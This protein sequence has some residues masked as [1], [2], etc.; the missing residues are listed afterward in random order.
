MNIYS[1]LLGESLKERIGMKKAIGFGLAC[2]F[3]AAFAVNATVIVSDSFDVGEAVDAVNGIYRYGANAVDGTD[4][5]KNA[6]NQSVVT[7]GFSG[8][9]SGAGFVVPLLRSGT[10]SNGYANLRMQ[11]SANAYRSLETYTTAATYYFSMTVSVDALLSANQN[12]YFG[13]AGSLSGTL[14]GEGITKYGFLLGIES[15]GSSMDLIARTRQSDGSPANSLK[16]TTVLSGITAGEEYNIL[17]R[18][19]VNISGGVD[20]FSVWVNPTDATEANNTA[21][22][23]FDAAS[24][25]LFYGMPDGG[26]INSFAIY[27]AGG[28]TVA[29][30]AVDNVMM[31]T[32][33]DEV[34][35]NVNIEL[36]AELPVGVIAYDSFYATQPGDA[37]NGYYYAGEHRADAYAVLSGVSN[38]SVTAGGFSGDWS[39][40]G[41]ATVLPRFGNDGRV[42]L[43]MLGNTLAYRSLTPYSGSLANTYYFSM[44]V[45][46]HHD[47]VP[48]QKAYFGFANDL[49][50]TL[51]AEGSTKYGFLLGVEKTNGVINLIAR[52]RQSDGPAGISLKDTVVANLNAYQEYKLIVRM[53]RNISDG[54]DGL[55]VW[56]DPADPVESN[57]VPT[58]VFDETTVDSLFYGALNQDDINSFAF[59]GEGETNNIADVRV[60]NVM[61]ATAFDV[62]ID[63]FDS[64]FNGA[65]LSWSGDGSNSIISSSTLFSQTNTPF[66]GVANYL[67]YTHDLVTTAWTNIASSAGT[68][69]VSWSFPQDGDQGF[70]QVITQ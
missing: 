13:F 20:G 37:E 64:V 43:R 50:G 29:N 22:L 4:A 48:A 66:E 16:D 34:Y 2:L 58:L 53:D 47:L 61:M 11:D 3:S 5:F 19:D 51:P 52:T 69:S 6:V 18:V 28:A 56:V 70:F 59:Y 7:T 39:G 49:G 35:S 57:N 41:Y 8:S 10:V 31:A 45:Q 60:D 26:S 24:S 36:P 65:K 23:V 55:K 54:V 63:N 62:V 21:D 30:V 27:G 9:W 33:F 67:Q 68:N 15:D 1:N 44:S 25:S 32:T 12:A 17:V 42:N 40:T 14:P 38:R 46:V